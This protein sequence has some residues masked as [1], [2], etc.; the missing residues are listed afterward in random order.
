MNT[1]SLTAIARELQQRCPPGS[2]RERL[3]NLHYHWAGAWVGSWDLEVIHSALE[4]REP[5]PLLITEHIVY[6]QRRPQDFE[7]A[8]TRTLIPALTE[9]SLVVFCRLLVFDLEFLSFHCGASRFTTY[10][11]CGSARRTQ[12]WVCSFTSPLVAAWRSDLPAR[13]SHRHCDY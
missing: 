11:A 5:H 3:R 4:R 1:E 6:N 12:P 9:V 10:R 13:S 7:E 2:L 8:I